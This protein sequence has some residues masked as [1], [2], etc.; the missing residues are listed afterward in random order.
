MRPRFVCVG[1]RRAPATL[2]MIAS[3]RRGLNAYTDDLLEQQGLLQRT[4]HAEKKRMAA[5]TSLVEQHGAGAHEAVRSLHTALEQARATPLTCIGE[6]ACE[7]VACSLLPLLALYVRMA[8]SRLTCWC[9][10]KLPG[11]RGAS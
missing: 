11:R 10:R 8:A 5:Y 9:L 2:V 1:C 4:L 6:G 3:L 7:H